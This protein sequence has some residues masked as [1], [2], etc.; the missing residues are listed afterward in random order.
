M[1]IIKEGKL[2]R[3]HKCSKCKTIYTYHIN[4]DVEIG[5][6]VYCP[7]CNNYMDIHC[8]DKKLN[9]KQVEKLWLGDSNG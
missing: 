9:K 5:E 7:N 6:L 1:E 4:N 2:Y 8:F 3:K